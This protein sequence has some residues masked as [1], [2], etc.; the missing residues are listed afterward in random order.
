MKMIFDFK[1]I[2]AIRILY[3]YW[4]FRTSNTY[5]W[6]FIYLRKLLKFITNHLFFIFIM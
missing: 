1:L 6:L 2:T 5:N 3:N 4:V